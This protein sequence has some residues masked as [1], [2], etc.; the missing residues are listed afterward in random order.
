[1]AVTLPSH[2]EA[3]AVLGHDA[4]KRNMSHVF[5]EPACKV[6]PAGEVALKLHEMCT[7]FSRILVA[8]LEAEA[9]LIL[10][11][12][13]E[14]D[15]PVFKAYF[16]TA[17]DFDYTGAA[18]AKEPTLFMTFESLI[19][20]TI[21]N[22]KDEGLAWPECLAPCT[23][24]KRTLDYHTLRFK[25]DYLDDNTHITIAG[26]RFL[27]NVQKQYSVVLLTSAS[28]KYIADCVRNV[29]RELASNP[30][31]AE[32]LEL[33]KVTVVSK[34]DA[35]SH[36]KRTGVAP[37]IGFDLN[38]YCVKEQFGWCAVAD[39]INIDG[40]PADQAKYIACGR[41]PS[42]EFTPKLGNWSYALEKIANQMNEHPG[43]PW[44][45]AKQAARINL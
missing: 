5:T 15:P 12:D 26:V 3:V 9:R 35:A 33:S 29:A 6:S 20:K 11:P 17:R 32:A 42:K 13:A 37:S 8:E 31:S 27:R 16:M 4:L 34:A 44:D 39:G 22:K 14:S 38:S 2:L 40:W 36:L 25:G 41:V 19:A 28:E 43:R 7:V 23:V 21:V 45:A 10:A 30:R 24:K 1:M 18:G